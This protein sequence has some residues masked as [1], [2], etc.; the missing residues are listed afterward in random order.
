M[1]HSDALISQFNGNYDLAAFTT[2][3]GEPPFRWIYNS[4]QHL[5]SFEIQ[6]INADIYVHRTFMA[7]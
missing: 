7:L 4:G 5:A 1:A 6:G 2:E 3:V